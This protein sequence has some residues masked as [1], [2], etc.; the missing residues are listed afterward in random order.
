MHIRWKTAFRRHVRV[1]M[2]LDPPSKYQLECGSVGYACLCVCMRECTC[3][4]FV[5]LST[6]GHSTVQNLFSNK[7]T[8]KRCA[9][10]K[11][12]IHGWHHTF[13]VCTHT[14]QIYDPDTG[15]TNNKRLSVS[16]LRFPCSLSEYCLRRCSGP[17]RISG[18]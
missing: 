13:L 9:Y 6:D 14:Q 10:T 4:F 17:G 16:I 11:R 1:Q 7:Y 18:P 8:Q 12:V 5:F 15:F 2:P 3:I